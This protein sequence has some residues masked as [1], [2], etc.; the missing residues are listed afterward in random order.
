MKKILLVHSM[1][2]HGTASMK[3][4]MSILGTSVL[5]VPSLLLTGLTNV[6]GHVKVSVD[7]ERMLNGSLEIA[8]NQ[9]EKLIL[10]VGYLGNEDQAH[11]ILRALSTYKDVIEQFWVDPVSGDHGRLYVPTEYVDMWPLL[12]QQADWAF[13]NLTEL[14]LYGGYGL[15]GNVGHEEVIKGFRRKFPDICFVGTSL[16]NGNKVGLVLWDGE[17]EFLHKHELLSPNFGGTG[18]VFAAYF[19]LKFLI[20]RSPAKESLIWAANQTLALLQQTIASG[21][22]FL[23]I[24]PY[25]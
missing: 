7:L 14:K 13:P 6:G 9:G 3:A 21:E 19:S 5:P 22:T 17:E 8:R 25:S 15:G 18:D 1:A 4:M 23:Q 20:K 11:I 16:Q 10:Y 24:N 12:L 2:T